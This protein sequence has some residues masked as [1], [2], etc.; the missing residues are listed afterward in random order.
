MANPNPTPPP[1]SG[2]FKK[3][4]SGNPGGISKYRKDLSGTLLYT[5]KELRQVISKYLRLQM[6][7]LVATGESNTAP[8]IDMIVAKTLINAVE[9]GEYSRIQPLIER[10]CGK[11]AEMTPE[12][13]KE[14]STEHL[15][16]L[17]DDELIALA[18][19]KT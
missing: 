14:P 7:E 6:P 12:E 15:D 11:P 13:S 10:V 1:K 8:A 3:G 18:K 5:N 9:K 16:G 19:S 4:Q 2:Q 17:S